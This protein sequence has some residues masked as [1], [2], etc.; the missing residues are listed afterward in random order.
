MLETTCPRAT[1]T[2]PSTVADAKEATRTSTALSRTSLRA[3]F[4]YSRDHRGDR[5]QIVIGLLCLHRPPRGAAA[6]PAASAWSLTGHRADICTATTSPKKPS[7]PSTTLPGHR[8]RAQTIVARAVGK[9]G[10]GRRRRSPHIRGAPRRPLRD[11]YYA[12]PVA[13][14]HADGVFNGTLCQ[15]GFCPRNPIDRKTMAVWIVRVLDGQ[16]P[17]AIKRSRFDDVDPTRSH[18]LPCAVHRTHGRTGRHN[19]MRRRKWV[20]S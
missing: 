12:M 3:A 13:D 14:L 4:G 2:G 9:G 17:P 11:A 18:Q 7:K 5:P 1:T 20:L 8:H 10:A 6:M 16:E 19:G 15:E